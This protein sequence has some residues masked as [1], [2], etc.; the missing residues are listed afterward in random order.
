MGLG[1]VRRRRWNEYHQNILHKTLKV[2]TE[3]L[4][5]KE[6]MKT[7]ERIKLI[8]GMISPELII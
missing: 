4:I 7:N 6:Q 5:H 8:F 2:L 3:K 1:E